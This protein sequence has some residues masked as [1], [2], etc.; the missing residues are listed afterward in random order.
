MG[1]TMEKMAPVASGDLPG[2]NWG[3]LAA[4]WD[5]LVHGRAPRGRRA[6]AREK[7]CRRLIKSQ[8]L[9]LACGRRLCA[10]EAS[11]SVAGELD[12]E[13]Q[14]WGELSAGWRQY[15][16]VFRRSGARA[17]ERGGVARGGMAEVGEWER[18]YDEL[19]KYGK[20]V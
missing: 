15:L 3:R 6:A 4:S 2:A 5:V 17:R 1:G 14:T 16:L 19:G 7:V 18:F 12:F 13:G 20:K 10:F 11:P 8:L 9:S